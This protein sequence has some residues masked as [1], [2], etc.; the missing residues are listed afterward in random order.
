MSD[1]EDEDE[2]D[3]LLDEI[4]IGAPADPEAWPGAE[5]KQAAFLTALVI[6]AGH[7]SEAAKAA[8]IARRLHYKWHEED[9]N[10]RK[11]F[12]SAST[13]AG[14]L[15]Q[16]EARRRAFRGVRKPVWW[17]GT[18]CGHELVYSDSLIQ[19]LLRGEFPEK[20]RERHQVEHTGL[21]GIEERLNAGRKRVAQ[22][23]KNAGNPPT[24]RD[25]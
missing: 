19:F 18:K 10:Y 4:A 13:Q 1:P 15:L 7:K 6:C 21:I 24:G 5:P 20:Y 22:R 17:Q 2:Q 14:E 23:K 8:R 3:D 25:S 12:A 11:L 16:D 9:A